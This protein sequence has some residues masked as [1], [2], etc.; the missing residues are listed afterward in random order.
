[1][2]RNKQEQAVE[3]RQYLKAAGHLCAYMRVTEQKNWTFLTNFG[4]YRFM[5]G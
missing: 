5:V 3:Y 2:N 4:Y 1:L